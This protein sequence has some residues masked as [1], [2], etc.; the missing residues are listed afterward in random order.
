MIPILFNASETNFSTNGLGRLTD[1]AACTV[2]EVLN[3]EFE[4]SMQYPVSGRLYSDIVHS[5]LILADAGDGRSA[6]AFRIYKI[7]KPISGIVTIQAEHISYQLT[8]I[9]VSP[10]TASGVVDA[11]AGMKTHAAAD[12][13]FTFWT[14]KTSGA[15]FRVDVPSSIRSNLGGKE[16]SVLDVYGGEYEFDQYL[17]NLYNRRGQDTDIRLAYGKNITDLSQEENISNT[18]TGVYP[19]WAGMDEYMELPEKTVLSD[20]SENYPYPRIIPL[21]C[22]QEWEQKPTEAQLRDYAEKY[23][24]RSG[25]GIPAVS[26]KVSF[27]ALWQT[28]EYKDVAPLE[29]VQLGDRVHVDFEV[30]GVSANAKVIKTVYNVLL[31][32]YDNI[33]LGE[34]RANMAVDMIAQQQAIN[35]K[36]SKTF[37]QQAVENATALITGVKGGYVLLNQDANGQPY[38]LLI[39][40]TSDIHTAQNVWRFNQAGW[41][42]SSTGYNGSYTLAATQDGAIVADFI[43]V[44][45]MLANRIKGGT[46]TLGGNGNGNGV[47]KVLDASGRQCVQLTKDGIE[48]IKGLIGGWNINEDSIYKDV[49]VSNGTIY[50]VSFRSPL[51][52]APDASLILSCQKSTDGGKTFSGIFELYSSGYVFFGS[53]AIEFNQAGQASFGNGRIVFLENGTIIWYGKNGGYAAQMVEQSD[54]TYHLSLGNGSV[55]AKNV[56]SVIN[57]YTGTIYTKDQGDNAMSIDVQDG[58]VVRVNH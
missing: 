54:G 50:R 16:G 43:T 34:T 27:I 31:N 48:A 7:S 52:I 6:Q 58:V 29:R 42:H 1:A 3:G 25:V 4:L 47:A 53:R 13:P 11:L 28:E 15:S 40:D 55:T 22:S 30:L 21:D 9:P 51:E 23:I 41:G 39:M 36:P 20:A 12:C 19:Y 44:G 56:P 14:D 49:A 2:T 46:L 8:K 37:L 18:V 33:E 17:I 57:R 5:A 35:S 24:S 38:E 26:I 10:F 32:R 45:T